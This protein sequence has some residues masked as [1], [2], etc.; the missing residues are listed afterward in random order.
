MDPISGGVAL[1]GGALGFLGGK[2]A[3]DTAKDMARVNRRFVERMS[4]T[5]YQRAVKDMQA[6]G[7]NPL[8]AY[9]QGGASTPGGFGANIE[10]QGAAATSSAAAASGAY[11]QLKLARAQV[12]NVMAQTDKTRAETQ[13]EDLMRQVKFHQMQSQAGLFDKQGVAID[14]RG[15]LDAQEWRFNNAVME[16]RKELE[17]LNVDLTRNQAEDVLARIGLTRVNT[18]LGELEIPAARNRAQSERTFW[19][20]Y[21]RPYLNDAETVRGV[22]GG[23]GW[24]RSQGGGVGGSMW[25]R[26]GGW[27]DRSDWNSST[28]VRW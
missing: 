5:A 10:N 19:G 25:D 6:A 24:S 12:E 26:K 9:Q 3:N 15:A 16:F 14:A 21:F 4:N 18:T 23:F 1:A 7:L 13:T 8:L 17:K 22:V 28:S 11:T 27:S 20:R 2:S